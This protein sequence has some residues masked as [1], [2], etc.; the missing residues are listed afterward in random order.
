MN[1]ARGVLKRVRHGHDDEAQRLP[2]KSSPKKSA[3][4]GPGRAP[5]RVRGEVLSLHREGG[6]PAGAAPPRPRRDRRPDLVGRHRPDGGRRAVRS[7][8]RRS[9]R[10][11]RRVPHPRRDARRPALARHAVARHAPALQR[12]ARRH[13]PPR[14]AARAHAR[15]RGDRQ[16]P[17]RR[18]RGALRPPAEALRLVGGR[19]RRRGPRPARAHRRPVGRRSVRDRLAPRDAGPPGLRHRRACPRRCSRCCRSTTAT[20]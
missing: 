14:G 17:G 8:A 19:H 16:A 6:P 11:L 13:P 15:S 10:G 9:V 7:E 3:E 1:V 4:E 2:T 12:A 5:E 18:R 20:T